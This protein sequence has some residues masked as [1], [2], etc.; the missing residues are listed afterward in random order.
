MSISQE[1]YT[2]ECADIEA[3]QQATR[4]VADYPSPVLFVEPPALPMNSVNPDGIDSEQ[5]C[6]SIPVVIPS[7]L[8]GD[9]C[10]N[11][12]ICGGP[13]SGKSVTALALIRQWKEKHSALDS[14]VIRI[15]PREQDL[16]LFYANCVK[17]LN[18]SNV[19]RR[20]CVVFEENQSPPSQAYSAF[21]LNAS[22][23]NLF[24]VYMVSNIINLAASYILFCTD[25]IFAM[26][27]RH[28][29]PQ[30]FVEVIAQCGIDPQKY[31]T[32]KEKLIHYF[33]DRYFD[34]DIETNNIISFAFISNLGDD[35]A[36]DVS[37][38]ISSISSN[39][40]LVNI[41]FVS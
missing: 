38:G 29:D 37:F 21:F 33:E 16:E 34:N 3:F 19:F 24:I 40:S 2:R 23:F 13:G 25:K 26:T 8:I 12:I 27:K 7:S 36:C 35:D 18:H 22:K 9:E 1:T 20:R 4:D 41:N 28:F 17:Q 5:V 6:N 10:E 14:D 32:L 15:A 30:P 31:S 39:G 11:I